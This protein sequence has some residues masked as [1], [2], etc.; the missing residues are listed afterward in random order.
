MIVRRAPGA[1]DAR[2]DGSLIVLNPTTSE[3]VELNDVAAAVWDGL[4]DGPAHVD[5]LAAA[6]VTEFDVD[7][8]NG[9]AAVKRFVQRAIEAGIVETV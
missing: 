9:R 1:V 4:V 3:F 8:E 6:V 2:V 5:V 7:P